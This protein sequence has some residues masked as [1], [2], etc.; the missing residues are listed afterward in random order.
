MEIL[1]LDGL[2][3]VGILFVILPLLVFM[4]N[5]SNPN[6][7][8]FDPSFAKFLLGVVILILIGVGS[9]FLTSQNDSSELEKLHDMQCESKNYNSSNEL[10]ISLSDN[11]ISLYEYRSIKNTYESCVKETNNLLILKELKALN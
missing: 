3:I 1:I 8:D 11:R 2:A 5:A 7:S 10:K 9:L 6:H 4:I